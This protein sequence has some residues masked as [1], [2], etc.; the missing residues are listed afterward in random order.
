MAVADSLIENPHPYFVGFGMGGDEG[1][2]SY[3]DFKPVFD[4]VAAA[5][6]P[7]T[8]HAGEHYGPETIIDAVNTLPITGI[9]SDY[10]KHP[11]PQL[12]EAGCKVTLNSDDPPYFDTN[13]GDEYAKAHEHFGLSIENLLDITRTAIDAAFINDNEKE[14]LHSQIDSWKYS[15]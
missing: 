4:K 12:R 8:T 9:N 14:K 6:Y 15:G 13:I 1:H 10:S 2:L 11:F 7:C 5:G 3:E